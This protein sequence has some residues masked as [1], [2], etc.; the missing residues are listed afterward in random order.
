VAVLNSAPELFSG[1]LKL[2]MK[3]PIQYMLYTQRSTYAS[4]QGRGRIPYAPN[5]ESLVLVD[6]RLKT[7]EREQR[8]L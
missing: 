5:M 8:K 1:T 3:D 6:P 7:I 2:A 4:H